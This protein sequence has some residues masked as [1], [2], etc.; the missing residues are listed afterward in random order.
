MWR[1]SCARGAVTVLS[2]MGG[3]SRGV[4]AARRFVVGQFDH[5]KL[6]VGRVSL[7]AMVA[8]ERI[9]RGLPRGYAGLGDQLRRALS[10][11][12]LQ[13]TEAIA[14]RGRDR[15]CRLRIARAEA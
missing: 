8:G 1:R 4:G 6:D 3:K 9:A 5:Q 11:A 10:G 12:Y 13:T 15:A 2:L 7:E 14:R